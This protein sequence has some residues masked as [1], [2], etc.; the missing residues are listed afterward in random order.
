MVLHSIGD[1][2]PQVMAKT[3]YIE[4]IRAYPSKTTMC[5]V[6]LG[7]KYPIGPLIGIS[8]ERQPNPSEIG[9]GGKA[10]FQKQP[11]MFSM[12]KMF[13]YVKFAIMLPVWLEILA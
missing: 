7:K 1:T 4:K 9:K 11:W 8:R 13:F 5:S 10:L 6:L 2:V 12:N 3:Q